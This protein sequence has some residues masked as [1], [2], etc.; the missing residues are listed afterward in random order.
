VK[1]DFDALAEKMTR[2]KEKLLTDDLPPVS[3]EVMVKASR[4]KGDS[5]AQAAKR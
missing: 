3:E 1:F 5:P 2:R 4:G